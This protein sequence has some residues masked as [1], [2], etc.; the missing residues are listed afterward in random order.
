M[1]VGH[2]PAAAAALLDEATELEIYLEIQGGKIRAETI[3]PEVTQPI[4]EDFCRRVAEN[5]AGVLV[6]LQM[7]AETP[8]EVQ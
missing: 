2:V 5:K 8:E 1:I 7:W 6:A 4:L 3:N